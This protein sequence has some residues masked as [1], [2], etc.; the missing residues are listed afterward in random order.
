MLQ[1]VPETRSRCA[2]PDQELHGASWGCV[3]GQGSRRRC[4]R[5]P[6][7]VRKLRR[8]WAAGMGQQRALLGMSQS[9][10][11]ASH[12]WRSQPRPPLICPAHRPV[13]TP[14][15]TA[16]SCKRSASGG[17]R[18][19]TGQPV[20]HRMAAACA[21][22]T[23][24][25]VQPAACC[26]GRTSWLAPPQLS[27]S[28]ARGRR[29]RP[30]AAAASGQ[31]GG[32]SRRDATAAAATASAAAG[33]TTPP[34][35]SGG[36][37]GVPPPPP[38]GLLINSSGAAS[39]SSAASA[40][41]GRSEEWLD[42]LQTPEPDMFGP[43]ARSASDAAVLR[44]KGHLKEQDKFIQFVLDMHQ[45]HT[46]LEV[47][48]LRAEQ[49]MLPPARL[50]G[51]VIPPPLARALP[52]P[53]APAC[54]PR[55]PPGSAARC[56]APRSPHPPT[57][58]HPPTLPAGHA[59]DGALDRGAPQGPAHQPP[60]AHGAHHRLLLRAA[61]VRGGGPR[62]A[63]RPPR[64]PVPAA[65]AGAAAAARA[66]GLA[67][68]THATPP[69]P[70]LAPP[71]RLVDAF[72]EYDEFFALSRRQYVH[73]NFAEMRH[74]LNIAQVGGPPGRPAGATRMRGRQLR[75]RRRGRRG[76]Q[77][78]AAA[79]WLACPPRAAPAPVR[80]PHA[81]AQQRA[82]AAPHHL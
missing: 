32:T 55:Q 78:R 34:G 46:S 12:A 43:R 30:L 66:A 19:K 3:C 48:A 59:E 38:G 80:P 81:G 23:V 20:K 75:A 58:P 17:S 21:A 24:S 16:A 76:A 47:R 70:P 57:H 49:Q 82:D 52:A 15:H 31:N 26:S 10:R 11:W 13:S 60:A 74:I 71:R 79:A 68:P 62:P 29:L 73:P 56:P 69:H 1:L 42:L 9:G 7:L 37:A 39:S 53:A 27:S 63:G 25:G 6:A 2:E 64:A 61:Q 72:M 33:R 36:G 41:G 77:G 5:R 22:T 14:E 50:T 44:R 35:G 51:C 28:V 4:T 40:S 18:A 54:G 45:T 65:R 67:A 8:R